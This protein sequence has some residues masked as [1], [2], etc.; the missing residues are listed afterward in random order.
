M[1]LVIFIVKDLNDLKN[2]YLCCVTNICGKGTK[3]IT[4]QSLEAVLRIRDPGSGI[5]C[6]FDPWIR[7]I[8]IPDPK[9]ILLLRD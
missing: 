3:I 4:V 8:R 1:Y 5:R 6:L 7:D 9:P 2:I